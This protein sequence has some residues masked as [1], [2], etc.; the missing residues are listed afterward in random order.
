[1][2]YF[3]FLIIGVNLFQSCNNAERKPPY[4]DL[5]NFELMKKGDQVVVPKSVIKLI[6]S[7]NHVDVKKYSIIVFYDG[8]CSVCYFELNKWMALMSD[9]DE[10]GINNYRIK[11]IL[12]G[13]NDAIIK[14]NLKKIGFSLDKVY[15]DSRDEFITKYSFL[16]SP[17]Y[18]Y[19]SMLM[20][21]NERILLIGN[22][23]N[24]PEIKSMFIEL[25]LQK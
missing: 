14:F 10:K 24:S 12:S 4:K 21:S 19:S 7:A 2:K 8:H 20:D 18:V 25:F 23:T 11:F 5:S 13:D 17:N 22:P 15:Y 6:D 3:L 9:L 1:M 16:K